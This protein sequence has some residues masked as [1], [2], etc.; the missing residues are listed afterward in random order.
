MTRCVFV[1]DLFNGAVVHAH[2]G[3]RETYEPIEKSSSLVQ[4]S[5]PLRILELLKPREIYVAD[6]DRITGSGHNL[7]LIEEMSQRSSAMVDWG[8]SSLADIDLLPDG[9]RP[10]LGTETA[11]LDLI[12]RASRSRRIVVSIDMFRR[13]VL[14]RDPRLQVPP[15]DLVRELDE[16]D[17][18]GIILLELD[19]V[20]TSAGIDEDFLGEAASLSSHDLILGGGVK[21]SRDLLRL[22]EL[23]IEGALVATA[24]HQGAIPVEA[25][26]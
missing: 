2:R 11:S 25:I 17:L 18:G 5:D 22:E 3:E 21:D 1:L 6:L 9:C 12:R 16:L 15:L 26:R 24:I 20:G 7:D 4:T 14:A 19:L 23:G 8:I 10:V 13:E